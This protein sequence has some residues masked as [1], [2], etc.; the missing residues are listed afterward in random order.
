MRSDLPANWQF[1]VSID[2]HIDNGWTI[3]NRDWPIYL[4]EV[5]GPVSAKAL[6]LEA[7]GSVNFP[8]TLPSANTALPPYL[9][10]RLWHL[11]DIRIRRPSGQLLTL[12]GRLQ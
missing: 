9:N 5:V 12:S 6:G 8:F 10:V 3:F 11:A 4:I 7:D 1:N 2:P